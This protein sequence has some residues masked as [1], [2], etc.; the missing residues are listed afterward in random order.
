MAIYQYDRLLPN[1]RDYVSKSQ[2]YKEKSIR[3]S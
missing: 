3:I 1:A 2:A